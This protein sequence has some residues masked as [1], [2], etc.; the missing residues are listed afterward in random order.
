MT[1]YRWFILTLLFLVTTN[2]YLDR[3]VFSVL[4]PDH[5]RRPAHFHRAVRLHQRRLPDGLHHRLPGRGE[6]HRP[7]RHAHR[8]HPLDP[9]VVGRR[10]PARLRR[11]RRC[12]L[13]SGAACWDSASRATSRPR[14]RRWPSGSRRRTAPSPRGSSTPGTNVASMVGPPLFRVDGGALRM[15]RLF[16]HHRLDRDSSWR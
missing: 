9:L 7:V 5:P 3:I 1:R 15:A 12:S 2:N 10:L 13:A 4:I 11:A 6:V 8:L 16:P 14:S